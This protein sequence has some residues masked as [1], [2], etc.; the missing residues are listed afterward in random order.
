RERELEYGAPARIRGVRELPAMSLDNRTA[1]PESDP[2]AGR[3]GRI[4][5]L[6]DPL[7]IRG[8]DARSAV[9]DTN[10]QLVFCAVLHLD[11]ERLV[12][13]A[14]LVHCLDRVAREVEHDLL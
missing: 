14:R 8:P 13:A 4:E 12:I 7:R 10:D 6:E 11:L 1:D 9:D 5:R 2:Q 3:L